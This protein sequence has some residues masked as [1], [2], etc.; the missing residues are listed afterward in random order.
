MLSLRPP[1]LLAGN[2]IIFRDDKEEENFY[3]ACQQPSLS[4]GEDGN[5]AISAYAIIP[6]SGV[7][8][9]ND[10][11]LE[12][13]LNIDVELSATKEE[14]EE[15]E[16]QI[17]KQ[18]GVRPKALAPAPIHSG[19]VYFSMAQS[20]EDPSKSGWYVTS[21]FKP[22]LV[23]SNKASL[24]VRTTGNDA[25]LLIAS[26]DAGSVPACVY[27]ELN[28]VGISPVY[29][30]SIEADMSM[31]YHHFEKQEKANGL[32][33]SYEIS[34]IID[35]LQETNALKI[36]VEELDPDIKAEAMSTLFNDL[37]AKVIADFFQPIDFSAIQSH[38]SQEK[39]VA[40][41]ISD[42]VTGFIKSIIPNASYKRK[43]I[44]QSQLRTITI[45]LSQ[46]NAKTYTY[47]PQSLLKTMVERANVTLSD[48]I[49][50]ISL[51]DLANKS[52]E[53][54]V[55]VATDAFESANLKTLE[56]Y[57]RVVDAETGEVK[58]DIVLPPFES[59][60]ELAT[61]FNY[62]RQRG[63]NYYYE[64]RVNLLMDSG[65]EKLPTRME[66]PW[67]RVESPYIYINPA[68]YCK[69]YEV[70]VYLEDRTMF[71]QTQMIQVDV[72]AVIGENEEAILNRTFVFKKDDTEHRRF[73]IVA[74]KNANLRYNIK[75]TYYLANLKEQVVEYKDVTNALF[76]IP[77]PFENKW[78]VD[79]RCMANWEK[80]ERVY[81]R[82]RI[83]DPDR[84]DPIT[85]RFVFTKEQTDQTL[86]V[87]CGLDTPQET[88]EYLIEVL[89]IDGD[90][91]LTSGWYH[92]N[93]GSVVI[94][95]V[96][97][98]FVPK[99]FLR[100]RLGEELDYK[101][102]EI[103]FIDV[104]LRFA[105]GTEDTQQMYPETQ[106][107]EFAHTVSEGESSTY[108]YRYKLK[109]PGNPKSAWI[110]SDTDILLITIDKDLL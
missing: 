2:L 41:G 51:D 103:Q 90:K 11:I 3:Y 102:W 10:D 31:I 72:A 40:E 64:Y 81:L 52:Q 18:Y 66:I 37:K 20:G 6:E 7:G 77:N 85:N 105:D 28:L 32:F 34:K 47:C 68:D 110:K 82:T 16:K 50:W 39:S 84:G 108:S 27:Y 94:L 79:I 24:V 30:A 4:I 87:A 46:N 5:A 53:V 74:D 83:E 92:H 54:N 9:K 12:A 59:G 93:G 56:V 63:V 100:V 104:T 57:C 99:R 106:M 43:T 75:L 15:A 29:H 26:V 58:T 36:V 70:D 38:D 22:S 101:K 35:D 96:K 45:D 42:A 107:L 62:H 25:K 14:L 44:D 86:Y 98:D 65:T 48:K 78:S 49:A 21:G 55:R 8:V 80:Y 1:F 73:S 69:D 71:D 19:V 89:P 76:F 97:D 60:S 61:M 91:V 109:C 88:F 13:G 33:L 17:Q 67:T 23:G 95:K